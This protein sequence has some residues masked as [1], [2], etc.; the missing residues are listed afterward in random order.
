MFDRNSRYASQPV[1]GWVDG[2]GRT[3]RFFAL[4]EVPAPRSQRSADP[5]HVVSDG[6]RLDRLTWQNLGDPEQYWRL[7]D[8]NGA[9]VPDELTSIR[10]RALV[11]PI[12]PR[13][14]P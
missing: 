13:I 4:R 8:A 11:V 3:R 10:G 5:I 9:L 2:A 1:L 7:C 12:D 14:D 6:E